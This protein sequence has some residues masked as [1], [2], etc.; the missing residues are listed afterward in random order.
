MTAM[1]EVMPDAH[2][3]ELNCV[4]PSIANSGLSAMGTKG[5]LGNN[6]PECTWLD[7]SDGAVLFP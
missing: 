3:D 1:Q 6:V 5:H 7:L 4:L 2:C